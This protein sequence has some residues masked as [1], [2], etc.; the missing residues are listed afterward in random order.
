MIMRVEKLNLDETLNKWVESC[1]VIESENFLS[2]I[3]QTLGFPE[4]TPE[5]IIILKGHLN[6]FYKE[7]SYQISKSC[8]FTFIDQPILIRP[9][10]NLHFIKITF[11]PLGVFPLVKLS[12][13]SSTE[14]TYNPIILAEDLFGNELRIL[15]SK[16]FESKS[17][18]ELEDNI[19]SFLNSRF[20][21]SNM[22]QVDCAII[23]QKQPNIYTVDQFCDS[24]NITPRTLQRWF[25]LNM[26]ISP[27]F[28]LKLLRL[29]DVIH[30]LSST[31]EYDYLDLAIKNGFYDQTHMIK[32][33]KSFMNQTPSEIPF[34]QYLPIQL[35]G[36]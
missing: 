21:K 11:H 3:P 15:E 16:L 33:I 31:N 30:D 24:L 32:E 18:S 14:L 26:D 17:N 4:A 25:V 2:F 19:T 9:S 34:D 36:L 7:Q 35:K 27:K 6:I 1:S 10:S 5:L 22:S 8:V 29:K 23:N 28:Y 12:G 20:N 13:I